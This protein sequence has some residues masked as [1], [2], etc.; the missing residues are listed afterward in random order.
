[1]LKSFKALSSNRKSVKLGRIDKDTLYIVMTESMKPYVK[2][3]KVLSMKDLIG[4]DVLDPFGQGR[5]EYFQT[6]NLINNAITKL[7]DKIKMWREL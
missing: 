6:A 2:G 5:E 4:Q 7:L 3:D 1:M